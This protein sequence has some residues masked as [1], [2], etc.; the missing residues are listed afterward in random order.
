MRFNFP[1]RA[2]DDVVSWES[3]EIFLA[4][5]YSQPT[6]HHP[7]HL[8]I[9]SIHI[10]SLTQCQSKLLTSV[11]SFKRLAEATPSWSRSERETIRQSSR[12]DAQ[13]I[14]THWLLPMPRKPT[15]WLNRFHL[16]C[17]ERT[18]KHTY[19]ENYPVTYKMSWSRGYRCLLNKGICRYFWL[20][21]FIQQMDWRVPVCVIL[22]VSWNGM[23]RGI[24]GRDWEN[25]IAGWLPPMADLTTVTWISNRCWHGGRYILCWNSFLLCLLVVV[26]LW[27][28]LEKFIAHKFP[29]HSSIV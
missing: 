24:W 20:I 3:K 8:V 9:Y 28:H 17:N 13:D 10:N 14:C 29:L 12:S 22:M 19:A 5:L 4:L 21:W 26:K 25:T 27:F 6:H 7:F 23:F 11:I 15:N 1:G 18:S 2:I 16:V